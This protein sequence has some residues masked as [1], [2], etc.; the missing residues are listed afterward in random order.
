MFPLITTTFRPRPAEAAARRNRPLE[1]VQ[2]EAVRRPA[3]AFWQT[4]KLTRRQLLVYGGSTLGVILLMVMIYMYQ[5]LAPLRRVEVHIQALHDN[6]FHDEASLA[7]LVTD[8]AG[9]DLTGV[10]MGQ[11][12]LGMVELALRQDRTV[13]H[14]EAWKSIA[15]SLHLEATLRK[16]LARLINNSGTT[17][18]LDEN[19]YKFP[20]S[21]LHTA[22]VPLIRGDFEEGAVDTFACNTILAAVPVLQYIQQNPFWNAQIAEIWIEQSGELVLY[23]QIGDARIEFGQPSRI[24]EKFSN[25]LDFYRQVL[26]ETGWSLYKSVSVAYRGQVV[27]RRR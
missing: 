5:E 4:G 19:G 10:P 17:L 11:I 1:E 12:D 18:Y 15:G 7:Q 20:D 24:R 16:P 22:Y 25:L 23:P 13:L 2:Q 8:A 14:G 21:R 26:P 27:A 9:M 6:A 3:P